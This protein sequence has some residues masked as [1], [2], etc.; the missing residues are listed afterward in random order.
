MEAIIK[1]LSSL[2]P[3][4]IVS[5]VI[6]FFSCLTAQL[7]FMRS[8]H[9]TRWLKE[10]ITTTVDENMGLLKESNARHSVKIQEIE[11]RLVKLEEQNEQILPKLDTMS[12]EITEIY[13]LMIKERR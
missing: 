3:A 12:K 8:K 1:F 7:L 4:S 9:Y 10:Q 5:F 6:G 2:L 11:K 13:R